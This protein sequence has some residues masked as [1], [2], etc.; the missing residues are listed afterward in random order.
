[1]STKLTDLLGSYDN[2][3]E[4]PRVLNHPSNILAVTISFMV[5]GC[6]CARPVVI[7]LNLGTAPCKPA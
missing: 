5:C 7:L 6:A 1:M 2:L 4:A 3:N